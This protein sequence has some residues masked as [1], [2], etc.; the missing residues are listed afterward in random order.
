M[1]LRPF[2]GIALLASGAALALAGCQ[3]IP[4]DKTGG[5]SVADGRPMGRADIPYSGPKVAAANQAV[6]DALKGL[7]LRPY[8][9]LTPAEARQQ[10]LFGDGVK[11]VMQ[12]RGLTPPMTVTE[13]SITIPGPGGPLTGKVYTPAGLTGAQPGILYFHGGG[14]VLASADAYGASARALAQ[15]VGAV[16]VSVNY[17]LAPQAKFPAQHDDALAAYR[18]MLRNAA[19]VGVDP[20]RLAIAGESAGGNLAVAT[21]VAARDAGLALPKAILSVYPVAGTDLNTPSYQANAQAFVLN[22][23]A[24]AWFLYHTMRSTAD[25]ADPRLNLVAANLTGLPPVTL[26]QAEVDPLRSEGDML[27]DRLRAAGVTVNQQ[28]YR[29]VTHEFFG[30]AAAIP[31]AGE[32]QDYAARNLKRALER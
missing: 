14:W 21:S 13:R 17:R 24:M 32:A 28:L 20:E 4:A 26:V 6:I 8:H 29:G 5:A 23:A 7:N 11:A 31:E 9:T 12:Q 22:R 16:V 27:A 19:T 30:A 10:P 15:K 18:W 1:T 25:A 3:T 2:G